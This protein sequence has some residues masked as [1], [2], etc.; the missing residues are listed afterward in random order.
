MENT[1]PSLAHTPGAWHITH[2]E[3]EAVYCG[4][5]HLAIV[6]GYST[7]ADLETVPEAEANA[8]LIAAAPSLLETLRAIRDD[9]D[10]WLNEKNGMPAEELFAAFRDEAHNIISEV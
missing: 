9:C 8:R 10:R 6:A 1:T 2:S 4:E 5:R 7:I 3:I